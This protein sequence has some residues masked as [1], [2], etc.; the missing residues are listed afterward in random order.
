MS[1]MPVIEARMFS[2]CP[3]CETAIRPGDR[4]T[5][6]EFDGAGK[7]WVH[8]TCPPEKAPRPVCTVCFME[9]ALNGACGCES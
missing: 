3:S 2:T 5:P 6:D 7:T 4:I 9:Q 1:A 8:E